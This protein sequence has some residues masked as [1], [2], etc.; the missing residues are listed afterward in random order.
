MGIGSLPF[1]HE[2]STWCINLGQWTPSD[3]AKYARRWEL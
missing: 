3:R 2:V 1:E